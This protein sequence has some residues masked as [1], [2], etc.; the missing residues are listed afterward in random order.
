VNRADRLLLDLTDALA[1]AALL[2]A[3]GRGDFDSDIA[4][5]LAFESLCNRVGDLA[6]QLA[7]VDSARFSHPIF[8]QAAR[9]RDFIV[10][11]YHRIDRDA[12]WVTVSRDFPALDSVVSQLTS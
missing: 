6:K 10:H 5:P 11:H 7:I 3:R 2:V 12:L 9:N 8:A 4:V 1:T